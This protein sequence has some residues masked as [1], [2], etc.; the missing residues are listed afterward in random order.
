MGLLYE[1]GIR[2]KEEKMFIG[3]WNRSVI[4]TYIGLVFGKKIGLKVGRISNVL[5]SIILILIGIIYLL[6]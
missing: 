4:L 5:G 3:K 2:V 6:K 1:I